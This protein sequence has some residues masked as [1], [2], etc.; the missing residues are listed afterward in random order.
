MAANNLQ[1]VIT[2]A[3]ATQSDPE[4][5]DRLTRGLLVELRELG[6]DSANLVTT[7]APAGTKGELVT[8]GS[9]V[10]GILPP[11]IQAVLEYI[12]DWST[13]G[14]G[15]LVKVKIG[16]V[17]MEFTPQQEMTASEMLVF[18]ERVRSL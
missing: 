1:A 12:R 9:I 5:L 15:T 7:Q 3:D 13:R 14:K 8:I 2:L 16:D 4:H 17:E 10:V 11:L 18:I 6:I